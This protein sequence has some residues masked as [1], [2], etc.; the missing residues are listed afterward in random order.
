MATPRSRKNKDQISF[1]KEIETEDIGGCIKRLVSLGYMVIPPIEISEVTNTRGLIDLF[2]NLR[3]R[4]CR[5]K[6]VFYG[7]GN[8]KEDVKNVSIFLKSRLSAMSISVRSL[9][10]VSTE[11]KKKIY[12]E[13]SGIIRCMFENESLL[14]LD[15]PIVSTGILKHKLVISKTLNI[16]NEDSISKRE[17][18]ESEILRILTSLDDE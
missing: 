3:D 9:K 5:E 10:E 7:R 6:K 14:G 1:Y 16:M 17:D 11:L 15:N 13:A 4:K 8:I 18:E 12:V 2:Y